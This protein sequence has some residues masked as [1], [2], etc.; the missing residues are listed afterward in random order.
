[1]EF[2]MAAAA[3]ALRLIAGGNPDLMNAVATSLQVSLTATLIACALGA[4][5]GAW[6]AIHDFPGRRSL[7]IGINAMLGLPPVV[8]GLVVYLLLSRSGPLGAAGLLF[9]VRAMVLAQVLLTLPI[10]VALAHRATEAGWRD[11]GDALRIDGTRGLQ[12]IRFLLTMESAALLTTF[13]AAF[14]RA[15]S[16]VGAIMIVGGNIRDHTRTITTA[17]VLETSKGEVAM[18][19]ALG[20][21]LV[22]LTLLVSATAFLLQERAANR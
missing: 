8:I 22:S 6:L 4:P 3:T 14:G 2:L 1:M 15:I 5:L 21:I 7:L 9:T 10:V 18:A 20:L 16:E 13:L 11:Y 12:C 17:V 19:L